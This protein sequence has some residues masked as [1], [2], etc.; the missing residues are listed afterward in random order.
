MPDFK[1]LVYERPDIE[2][3]RKTVRDIRLKLMTATDPEFAADTL[4]EY[5]REISRIDTAYA[6]C[7]IKH[8]LNTKDEFFVKELEFFDEALATVSELQAAVLSILLTC[9]CKDALRERF[10]DM[11]FRKAQ[12]HKDTI[13]GEILD[14]LVEESTLEN[15][16]SQL[17]S[18][19][20]IEFGRETLNLSLL[21]P[22]LKSSDRKVRANAAYA[23]DNYY[24]GRKETFDRIYDDMVRVRTQAARKLGYKNFTEL[25]YKRMERYDYT[26]EDV[27][28]FRE[29]IV[30]YFVPLSVQIRKNQKERLGYEKLMFYDLPALFLLRCSF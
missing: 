21:T 29:N 7:N 4:F 2:A 3:F 9:P 23:L 10:G 11:I 27:E 8:D 5:E 19:A 13:S 15:E 16:Y 24:M 22:Y 18:E 25:G 30:K 12:N 20:S 1:D 26:R 14:E 28:K 6:L 17:Q